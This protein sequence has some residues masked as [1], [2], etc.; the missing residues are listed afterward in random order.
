MKIRKIYLDKGED[1][2]Y[3]AYL[4]K[5]INQYFITDIELSRDVYFINDDDVCELTETKEKEIANKYY[6]IVSHYEKKSFVEF[7]TKQ[8][9]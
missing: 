8:E 3:Y 6:N 2:F 4:L 1:Y 7:S 5:S 9:M